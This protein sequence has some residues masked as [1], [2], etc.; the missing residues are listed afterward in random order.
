MFLKCTGTFPWL[1][2]SWGFKEQKSN[3]VGKNMKNFMFNLKYYNKVETYRTN[4][5]AKENR[6]TNQC[7]SLT[8]VMKLFS[9]ILVSP[10][11][12][13]SLRNVAISNCLLAGCISR[14]YYSSQDIQTYQMLPSFSFQTFCTLLTAGNGISK[15]ST[16]ASSNPK[17]MGVLFQRRYCDKL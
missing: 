5:S 7:S 2:C 8:M 12:T 11:S 10:S 3:S 9:R 4:F 15:T 1:A 14:L 6:V 17:T 16:N 13:T